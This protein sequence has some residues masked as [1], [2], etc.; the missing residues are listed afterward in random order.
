MQ[1]VQPQAMRAQHWSQQAWIILQHSASPEV[2]VMQQPS[3]VISQVHLHM[4]M[5]QQQTQ[6]PFWTQQTLQRQP[7]DWA[8]R[9]WI[10][11][12]V[13][14]SS[15][16]QIIFMPPAHFSRVILHFGTVRQ[17][18]WAA[19]TTETGV[20]VTGAVAVAMGTILSKRFGIW[21]LR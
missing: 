15:H 12:Q 9:A 4:V 19:G 21:N 2:Q 6:L 20:W 8:Q 10:M 7:A 14:S 18:I 16:L 5:L 3:A 1:Q 11:L 17:L 13:T